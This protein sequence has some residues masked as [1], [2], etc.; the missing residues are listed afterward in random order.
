M[1]RIDCL[2]LHPVVAGAVVLLWSFCQF[3]SP[4]A[5]TL[6]TLAHSPTQTAGQLIKSPENTGFP[7]FQTLFSKCNFFE[8]VLLARYIAHASCI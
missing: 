3:W 8:K 7:A 4:A 5:A 6:S 2:C 1:P